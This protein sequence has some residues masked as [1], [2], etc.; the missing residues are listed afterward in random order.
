ML[1][2]FRRFLRLVGFLLFTVFLIVLFAG[3]LLA[4]EQSVAVGFWSWSTAPMSLPFVLFL[5]FFLG[6][7][8]GLAGCLYMVFRLRLR[9][10][11]LLRKL[12][13]RDAELQKLRVSALR[14]L[15]S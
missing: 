15:S 13:R 12:K 7:A 6:V 8:I 9:N 1:I 3:L 11:S 14:G 10:A 5:A 4:N 2:K